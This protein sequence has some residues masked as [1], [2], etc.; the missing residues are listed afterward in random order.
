VDEPQGGALQF[1]RADF[2]Q[3]TSARCTFCQAP[4]QASYFEVNGQVAC[5]GC[6]TQ[7][8]EAMSGGSG[9]GR[10]VRATVLGTV[11]AV[12]G[13]GIWYGV[14]A[15]PPHLEIG[16][17]SIIVGL[18]VGAAVR[19]GAQRRGG[20]LYQGL[21]MWLTY[22]AIVST[23]IPALREGLQQAKAEQTARLPHATSPEAAA[24]PGAAPAATA[25]SGVSDPS[26]AEAQLSS[27]PRP[28]R[29]ALG[30]L[31]LF[32]LACFAPFLMGFQNIMGLIII[33]I[34]LYEAWKINKRVPVA[35]TGPYRLS[36]ATAPS[37]GD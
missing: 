25:T 10:F 32:V 23:Y 15:I 28:V 2:E 7:L 35:I 6:R 33:G 19:V 14:R 16:F 18:L 3:P 36:A 27:L 22:A 21:A 1:D 31:L 34:G 5:P 37:A 12:V 13:A 4:I 24:S 9:V 20:W 29:M 8:E 30:L 11:A 26:P 17:V